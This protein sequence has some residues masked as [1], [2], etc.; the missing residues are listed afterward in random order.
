MPVTDMD[1]DFEKAPSKRANAPVIPDGDYDAEIGTGTG[2]KENEKAG[3]IFSFKFTVVG[4]EYHGKTVERALF[5]DKKE[6]TDE[7]KK[8][9]RNK[10]LNEL[11]VDLK[12]LGFDVDHWTK[13]NNRPFSQQLAL[14]IKAMNGMRVKIRQKTNGEYV[15]L[16]LNKRLP[17]LDGKPAVLGEGELKALGSVDLGDSGLG[18]GEPA[19]P[20]NSAPPPATTWG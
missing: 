17:E 4:G 12:S 16:Y 2:F 19:A 11:K 10:K 7:E 15:N 20:A 5:F 14:A 18:G 9:H 1:D 13:A 8:A 3:D 6:G